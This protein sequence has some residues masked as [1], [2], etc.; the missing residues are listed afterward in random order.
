MQNPLPSAE[1]L[2]KAYA[3]EYAPYRPAWNASGWQLWRILRE[4]TTLRRTRRLKYFAK[5]SKLLEV[6][7]GAGD[8]LYAASYRG[9]QVHAVEYNK[10]LADMLRS[11]LSF[12]VRTGELRPKLWE[13]ESFDVVILWSVLEHVPNPLETLV[14][15]SSY[16]K[17]G[18]TVLFQLPT[19]YEAQFG[20]YFKQHW[21]MDLPRHLNFFDRNS[22]AML[23]KRAGME[24]TVFKTPFLDIAWCYLTSCSNYANASKRG[25]WRVLKL[26][27]LTSLVILTLPYMAVQALLGHGTEA[28]AVAVKR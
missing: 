9:W 11:Q 20:K 12:D 19:I 3:I 24:L 26:A 18:R 25:V 8:F 15:V 28:F 21:E 27:F 22:L 14:T 13:P 7:C 23:C 4:L 16:L 10:H 6:G 2:A 1:E 17:R 5:G